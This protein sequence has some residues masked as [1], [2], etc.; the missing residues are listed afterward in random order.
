MKQDC[1]NYR[2]L[3]MEVA[4]GREKPAERRDLEA[5]LQGCEGCREE[6]ASYARLN[7][8][9]AILRSEAEGLVPRLEPGGGLLA[10]LERAAAPRRKRRWL[11]VGA[12]AATV[13][14]GWGAWRD[15]PRIGK[16]VL[17]E[18]G[19]DAVKVKAEPQKA[20]FAEKGSA[21]HA[22]ARPRRRNARAIAPAQQ[23]EPFV[24]IPFTAPLTP[25]EPA[26]VIR[27]DLP[28]SALIASGFP[29]QVADA[30]ASA[31]ADLVVGQDGR[32]RAVRLISISDSSSKSRGVFHE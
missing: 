26:D 2:D 28:V 15:S 4:R 24:A 8:A 19:V 12:I 30:G 18:A 3:L 9:E 14:L 25:D 31:L 5:H 29:M 7:Q 32:A 20:A 11:A 23:Q 22:S 16:P 27:M 13:L 6:F 1:R 10:E 17:R 21:L